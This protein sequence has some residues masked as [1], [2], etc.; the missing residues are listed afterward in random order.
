MHPMPYRRAH[1]FRL[2][3]FFVLAVLSAGVSVAQRAPVML[4]NVYRPGMSLD[5]YWVSEK[6]DGVRAYWDGR[7]L[8]TRGGEEIHAPDWFTAGWPRVQ[9]DGELWAG[10]GRFS[11]AVSTVRQQ[12]PDDAAWRQLQF[13]VFDLPGQGGAFSRRLAVLPATVQGIGLAWVKAVPQVKVASHDALQS[14]LNKVMA[15]GG[16]G[17]MLHRGA[18]LYRAERNDDLL[19]F[20]PYEDTEALVVGHVPGKGKYTGMLGALLVETPQGLRFK[21]GSGLTDAQR[22]RPPAIGS[23]VTYRYRGVNDSGIPRFAV[24]MRVRE[25]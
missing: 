17:L 16:E 24:F 14:M 1:V 7:R 19:K 6:F 4:A 2:F 5:D 9:L 13:M 15:Q 25:D 21:L 8:L 23:R 11:Q 12:T 10:H 18:S 3:L 22:S 20:K